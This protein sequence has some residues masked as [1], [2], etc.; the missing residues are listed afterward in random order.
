MTLPPQHKTS[1]F[2]TTGQ[3][4]FQAMRIEKDFFTR[5][6]PEII[7]ELSFTFHWSKLVSWLNLIRIGME[8]V[9]S[10]MPRKEEFDIGKHVVSPL[11]KVHSK[12]KHRW[13]G[14]CVTYAHVRWRSEGSL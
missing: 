13:D 14:H 5:V 6:S 3:E 10:P 9:V 8:S 4:L 2:N 12:A 1:A 11:P 7:C